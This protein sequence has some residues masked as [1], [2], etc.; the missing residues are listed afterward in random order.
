MNATE[1][2][3]GDIQRNS[4]LKIFKLFAKGIA[5]AHVHSNSRCTPLA[6]F[7]FLEMIA[8]GFVLEGIAALARRPLQGQDG[9]EAC[10]TKP[11]GKAA[12]SSGGS[13]WHSLEPVP[14]LK[15]RPKKIIM[16]WGPWT[17]I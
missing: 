2:I 9:T 8:L 5:N 3:K 14:S 15:V 6:V 10:L 4:R 17:G 7:G 1:V 11:H 13:H 12:T 16:R